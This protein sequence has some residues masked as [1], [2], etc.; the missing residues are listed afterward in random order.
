MKPHTLPN[1]NTLYMP[2]VHFTALRQ[3]FSELNVSSSLL[4]VVVSTFSYFS[5]TLVQHLTLLIM[6]HSFPAF[7]LL[8]L[9][10]K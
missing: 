5:L 2:S 8:V 4:I 3:R 6:M 7:P 1:D 10:T 9:L